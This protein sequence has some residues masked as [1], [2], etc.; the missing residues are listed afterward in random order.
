[1]AELLGVNQAEVSKMERRSELYV[2]ILRKF[3]EAMNGELAMQIIATVR[4]RPLEIDA[5]PEPMLG[6]PPAGDVE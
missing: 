5:I 4:W 3:I 1:M 2:G 6:R